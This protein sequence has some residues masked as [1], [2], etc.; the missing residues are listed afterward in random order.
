MERADTEIVEKLRSECGLSV[1]SIDDLVNTKERYKEAYPAL[2]QLLNRDYPIRIREM[3]VRSLTVPDA[4]DIAFDRLVKMYA[5]PEHVV[6]SRAIG[7]ESYRSALA[8]AISVLANRA[9]REII[10]QLAQDHKYGASRSAFVRSMSRWKDRSVD[11][12]VLDALSDP[13]TQYA[14][15]EAAGTR[16]LV[17]AVPELDKLVGSRNKDLARAAKRALQ[18]MPR[19]D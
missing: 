18:R 19:V 13:D 16:R 7:Y 11:A 10:K 8:N 9:D 17:S 5:E 6:T 14:A 3:I 12:I 1:T 2:L 15:V 4:R